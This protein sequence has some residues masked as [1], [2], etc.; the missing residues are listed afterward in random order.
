MMRSH[1]VTVGLP[2]GLAA[3]LLLMVLAAWVEERHDGRARVLEMA[4]HDIVRDAERL[5]LAAQISLADHPS[6]VAAEV[7]A[8]GWVQPVGLDDHAVVRRFQA[9]FRP[10][11]QLA[12]NVEQQVGR[13]GDRP[14]ALHRDRAHGLDH[15]RDHLPAFG[16]HVR[17]GRGQLARLRQQRF[18]LGV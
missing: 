15:L 13:D 3:G 17:C 1:S 18:L 11:G 12:G 10:V 16:R 9:D 7:A 8:V 5:A 4:R 2:L 6:R 14:R